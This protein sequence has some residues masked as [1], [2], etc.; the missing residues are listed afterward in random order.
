[1]CHGIQFTGSP[2]SHFFGDVTAEPFTVAG[3]TVTVTEQLVGK[4]Q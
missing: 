3:A 4:V 1:M 2:S